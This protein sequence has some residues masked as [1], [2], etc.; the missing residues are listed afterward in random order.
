MRI[1]QQTCALVLAIAALA[2]G[3]A[4]GA[5]SDAFDAAAEH[6]RNAR[7]Q[8][9][10][11]AFARLLESDPQ[12][13]RRSDAHF[14]YGEALV[15]LDRWQDARPHFAR[16]LEIDNAGQRAQQSLFRVGEAA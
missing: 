16:V 13:A 1:G 10:C 14:F 3:A 8:Q 2:I 9:A 4:R 12:F 7:W 5:E 15:Q 6:Y 11:D